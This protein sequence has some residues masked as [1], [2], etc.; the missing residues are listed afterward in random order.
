M[1]KIIIILA[2][3]ALSSCNQE[4]KE[5][6]KAEVNREI[7]LEKI[8]KKYKIKYSLL[9]LDYDY[10]YQFNPVIKDSVQLLRY[11]IINDIYTKNEKTFLSI[12]LH[13]Y[14]FDLLI[15]DETILNELIKKKDFYEESSN[16]LIIKLAKIRKMPF[17]LEGYQESF[18]DEIDFIIEVTGSQ[19][20]IGSGKI[21]HLIK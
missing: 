14:Y 9:D 2:L 15:E 16:M 17:I 3:V 10:S 11:F 7:K 5:R 13:K 21:L 6:I 18:D 12:N 19:K 4:E 8:K 1:K 20:F